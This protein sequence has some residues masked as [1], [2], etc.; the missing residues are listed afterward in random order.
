MRKSEYAS[1]GQPLGNEES[2]DEEKHN[3]PTRFFGIK[4]KYVTASI[5]GS[6]LGLIIAALCIDVLYEH[7][8]TGTIPW[9]GTTETG[10][11]DFNFGWKSLTVKVSYERD[12]LSETRNYDSSVDSDWR[13]RGK[14][15]LAMGILSIIAAAMAW[16]G[17][18]FNK[19]IKVSNKVLAVLYAVSAVLLLIGCVVV[20]TYDWNI[21]SVGM[22]I[23]NPKFGSSVI[24]GFVCCCMMSITA[25]LFLVIMAYKL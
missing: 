5:G 17:T 7:T 1:I 18:L 22:P 14:T 24:I 6:A 3:E 10:S 23:G 11:F 13:S 9:K 4:M 21:D 8:F 25:G 15:W 20:A 19:F 16:I 12:S 2:D